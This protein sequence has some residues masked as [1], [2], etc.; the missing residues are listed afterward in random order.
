MHAT[1]P[2]SPPHENSEENEIIVTSDML[3]NGVEAFLA[4]RDLMYETA[5]EVVQ[6]ILTAVL[7]SRVKFPDGQ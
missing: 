5:D 1:N 3:L 2:A 7:G 4:N 6:L